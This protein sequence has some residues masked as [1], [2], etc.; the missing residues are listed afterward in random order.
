MEYLIGSKI[1]SGLVTK[2]YWATIGRLIGPLRT[3]EDL[4]VKCKFGIQVLS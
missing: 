2:V 1:F 4:N 3:L